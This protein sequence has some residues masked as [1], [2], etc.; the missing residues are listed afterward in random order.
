MLINRFNVDTW[1]MDFRVRVGSDNAVANLQTLR[2]D[3]SAEAGEL[4]SVSSTGFEGGSGSG[5][6][7]GNKMEMLRA[8][9]ELLAEIDP[10]SP[11]TASAALPVRTIYPGGF[12]AAW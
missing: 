3:I 6:V 12:N 2:A 7:T 1:K 11:N 9:N 5:V 4:I 8:V 10:A